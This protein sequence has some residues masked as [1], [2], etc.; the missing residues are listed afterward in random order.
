MF[1]VFWDSDVQCIYVM[2]ILCTFHI[3]VSWVWYRSIL[4]SF[5]YL[6][7]PLSFW[8]ISELEMI[9]LAYYV[10]LLPFLASGL[11]FIQI[12]INF[13]WYIES[14]VLISAK[15]YTVR[16]AS[17]RT[18]SSEDSL[19]EQFFFMDPIKRLIQNSLKIIKSEKLEGKMSKMLRL[20]QQENW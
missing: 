4:F 8:G 12:L 1:F 17:Q 7:Q 6:I 5:P 2:N 11:F 15:I 14:F 19:K 3:S 9:N 16:L 13:T 10:K 18:N 20:R